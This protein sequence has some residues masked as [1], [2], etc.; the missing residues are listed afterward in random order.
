MERKFDHMINKY[1]HRYLE[2][3]FKDLTV[4]RS[5]APYLRVIYKHGQ[6]KMNDLIAKFFFHKSHT[7]RAINSLVKDGYVEKSKDPE[8]LRGYILSI[9]EKGKEVGKKLI[10]ILDG[11][12]Q[13]MNSFLEENEKEFIEKISQKIYLKLREY[14]KEDTIDDENA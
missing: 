12:D 6:I 14:F 1:H 10:K 7:T 8:D 9:T 13:L 5:E 2:E 4:N 3:R 11:W